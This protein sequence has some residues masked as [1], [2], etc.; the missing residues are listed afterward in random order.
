MDSEDSVQEI[1]IQEWK[2]LPAITK[3]QAKTEQKKEYREFEVIELSEDSG[4]IEIAKEPIKQDD[5][6]KRKEKLEYS[7]SI[8]NTIEDYFMT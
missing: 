1:I 4:L 6:R 7:Y 2:T 8:F 3:T 5:E